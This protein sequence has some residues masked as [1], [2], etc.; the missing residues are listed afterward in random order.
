[1]PFWEAV[2]DM[3]DLNRRHTLK[4]L[5]GLRPARDEWIQRGRDYFEFPQ[6]QTSLLTTPKIKVWLNEVEEELKNSRS[7]QWWLEWANNTLS[8]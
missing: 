3:T 7:S 5:K 8:E 6:I 1:M 4:H 2:Q